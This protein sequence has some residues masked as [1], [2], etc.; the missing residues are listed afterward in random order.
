[1]VLGLR[2]RGCLREQ[3]RCSVQSGRE[4]RAVV[5]TLPPTSFP[6][7]AGRHALWSRQSEEP[8]AT[9]GRSGNRTGDGGEARIDRTLP[10]EAIGRDG[11]SVALALIIAH[12]HGAGLQPAPGRT[13]VAR[14]TVSEP[15]A[16]PIHTT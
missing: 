3:Q 15:P 10:V 5:R 7:A 11:D 6:I 1:M 16:F 14:Q 8:G 12:Q 13:A 2:M 4:M 9:P